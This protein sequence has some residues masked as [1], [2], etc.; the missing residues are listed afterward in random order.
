[1]E[2]WPSQLLPRSFPE[3]PVPPDLV[4]TLTRL[5]HFATQQGL[6]HLGP[7]LWLQREV[8]HTHRGALMGP[9]QRHRPWLFPGSA[10][11]RA[12]PPGMPCVRLSSPVSS[13]HRQRPEQGMGAGRPGPL[14][15][16]GH[17]TIS[18]L[19]DRQQAVALS[20]Q[21]LHHVASPFQCSQLPW[22]AGGSSQEGSRWNHTQLRGVASEAAGSW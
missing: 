8:R 19:C 15:R 11:K 4:P 2:P 18:S 13:R 14:Q 20:G 21:G 5:D 12:L 22:G 1:M 9:V 6:E 3:K 17:N 10:R 7:A 16:G